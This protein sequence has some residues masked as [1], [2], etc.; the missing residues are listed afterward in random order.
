MKNMSIGAIK[1]LLLSDCNRNSVQI[2][3]NPHVVFLCDNVPG[4]KDWL[5]EELY[6]PRSLM[7]LCRQTLRSSLS[8]NGLTQV[9]QLDIP[10]DLQDFI[11]CK[12]IQMHHLIT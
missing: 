12:D 3:E 6:S 11:L 2:M 5:T 4:F 9:D 1:C 10:R 7:R 8:P